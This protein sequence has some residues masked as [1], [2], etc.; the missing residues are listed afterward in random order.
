MASRRNCEVVGEPAKWRP[1]VAARRCRSPA[2]A[3]PAPHRRAPAWLQP[4]P[5]SSA[6]F[7]CWWGIR[8]GVADAGDRNP[9]LQPLLRDVLAPATGAPPS[10]A[11]HCSGV[12]V[13]MRQT[14]SAEV[15]AARRPAGFVDSFVGARR[16][17]GSAV[18]RRPPAP[19]AEPLPARATA[20]L[21]RQSLRC[22][23]KRS[24]ALPGLPGVR[25]GCCCSS[26]GLGAWWR[27]SLRF[28][29]LGWSAA[30]CLCLC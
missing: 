9:V 16:R 26:L 18:A 30:F 13:S 29:G 17:G 5:E 23:A 3:R 10:M 21:L 8:H 24:G 14:C 27:I 6:C 12:M 11:A 20:S 15:R 4:A 2:G 7:E 28:A 1:V 22:S 25:S 19:I